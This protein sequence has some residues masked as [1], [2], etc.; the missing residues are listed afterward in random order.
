MDATTEFPYRM[1]IT[2]KPQFFV[3]FFL[4]GISS[5]AHLDTGE[6]VS[7]D[8]YIIDLGYSPE[9]LHTYEESHIA[10]RLLDTERREI[11]FD[12]AWIRITRG[13]DIFL[14]TNIYPV[15]G[16]AAVTYLFP[17]S[18]E[19]DL[20]VRFMKND[21]ALVEHTFT[22]HVESHTNWLL[23]LVTFLIVLVIG[24]KIKK[25]KNY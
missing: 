7:K 23:L 21:V 5:I 17:S 11:S 15:L 19:Y 24:I 16:N 13:N 4:L 12:H 8:A 14:S 3:F 1:S 22:L 6:D 2:M 18:G 20:T 10:L 9:D 25:K